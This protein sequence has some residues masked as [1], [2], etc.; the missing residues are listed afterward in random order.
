LSWNPANGPLSAG[1]CGVRGGGGG[2][3]DEARQERA[4]YNL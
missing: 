3:L 1:R 2:R 4:G